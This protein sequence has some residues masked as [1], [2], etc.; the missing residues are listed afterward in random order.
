MK[1]LWKIF[2]IL[3]ITA[4][5]AWVGCGGGAIILTIL[6][7]CK[8]SYCGL[9]IAEYAI[10]PAILLWMVMLFLSIAFHF[11]KNRQ[12]LWF[13]YIYAL[14]FAVF[15]WWIG[16]L[17]TV[18]WIPRLTGINLRE[19]SINYFITIWCFFI[20]LAYALF[21]IKKKNQKPLTNDDKL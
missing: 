16:Y 7:P 19:H 8:G 20:W 12:I 1:T 14:F 13:D 5:A 6:T 2:L 4:I 11:G 18:G 9:I 15:T 17:L 10:F 21:R 3:F